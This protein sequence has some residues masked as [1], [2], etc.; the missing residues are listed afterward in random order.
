M[1]TRAQDLARDV[2]HR[3]G[4]ELGAASSGAQLARLLAD[5]EGGTPAWREVAPQVTDSDSAARLARGLL[6]AG[7]LVFARARECWTAAAAAAPTDPAS[8]NTTAI[9]AALDTALAIA[10]HPS[11]LISRFLTAD[12]SAY[13]FDQVR[14]GDVVHPIADNVALLNRLRPGREICALAPGADPDELV[15]FV[16]IALGH[17]APT[18][19]AEVLDG[20]YGSP[21][22]AAAVDT[23][24]FYSI[25]STRAELRGVPFGAHL[26]ARAAAEL[27]RVHSGL[28]T[29]VTLSPLPGFRRWLVTHNPDLLAR[30]DETRESTG[31]SHPELDSELANTAATYL[32]TPAPGAKRVTDP[33]AR[34]HLG[35]GAQLWRINLAGNLADYGWQESCGVMANYLYELDHVA[36]RA[37][38]SS[39]GRPSLSPAVTAL[40]S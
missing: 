8:G 26:I 25:N 38:D 10:W 32:A 9:A 18:T 17:G 31:R 21:D 37:D 20:T 24:T 11:T 29:F 33:V 7:P 27:A 13:V 19:I 15:A 34:F 39:T 22:M 5:P 3:R 36:Q 35:N 14:F 30:L 1:P 2:L 40:L 12:D 4:G 6:F 16:E 28:T 23:A